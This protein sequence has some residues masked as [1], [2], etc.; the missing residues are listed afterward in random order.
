MDYIELVEKVIDVLGLTTIDIVLI[1]FS[2]I[3]AA[4]G[5]YVH[6]H[7]VIRNYS[8]PIP[9]S[10]HK[11]WKDN[12]RPRINWLIG[13][14]SISAITGLCFAFFFVGTINSTPGALFRVLALA[15]LAGYS[16]HSIWKSQEN[17][18]IKDF[19][20]YIEKSKND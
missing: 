16:A 4:M 6:L 5:G 7:V 8:E 10:F 20:N 18:S 12:Y 13:H 2:P 17:I 15:T 19:S 11:S 9:E 14:L 3:M 1:V